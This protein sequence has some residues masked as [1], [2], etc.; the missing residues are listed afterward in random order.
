MMIGGLIGAAVGVAAAWAY[1]RT[2]NR[3]ALAG[4]RVGYRP[5]V[6]SGDLM[7]LAITAIPVVRLVVDLLKP[8]AEAAMPLAEGEQQKAPG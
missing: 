2:G 8:P 3:S 7:K 1:V 5:Q 4:N 6:S